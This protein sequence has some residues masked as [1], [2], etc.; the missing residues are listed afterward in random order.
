MIFKGQSESQRRE[1]ELIEPN[2][3]QINIEFEYFIRK[4][5]VIIKIKIKSNQ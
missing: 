3:F 4:D 1:S 5:L 2:D